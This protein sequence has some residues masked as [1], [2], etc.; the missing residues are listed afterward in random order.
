MATVTFLFVVET[1]IAL[2]TT[3][4]D[5]SRRINKIAQIAVCMAYKGRETRSIEYS[6]VVPFS[7]KQ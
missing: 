6:F 7:P 2:G 1:Y 4:S 3:V 5:V